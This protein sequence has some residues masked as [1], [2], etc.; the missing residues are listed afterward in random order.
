MNLKQM[1]AFKELMLTGSVSKAAMNLH[2]TQPTVSHLI[3]TFEDEL[4]MKLFVREGKRLTPVPETNYL[5]EECET[6]LRRIDVISENL[7]RMKAM[8]RGEMRVVSMPGPSA[9]L[10]PAL[11]SEHVAGK[12]DIKATVMSRSSEAVRHLVSS[13]QFD[14]GLADHDPENPFEGTLLKAEIFT[15]D[16]VCALPAGDPLTKKKSISLDDL[17]GKPMASLFTEHVIHK[18]TEQAFASMSADFNLRFETNFF[19]QLLTFVQRKLAYAIID[20][21]TVE[22]YRLYSGGAEHIVFR[23]LEQIIEFGVEKLLPGYRPA[24]I[25]AS[26]FEDRLTRELLRLG[27]KQ[28]RRVGLSDEV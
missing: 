15:F 18:R 5:L 25:L 4:E 7:K 13:Q 17:S 22:A 19:I 28:I 8:D 21:L 23:P 14:L 9:F 27:A 20:P 24:S 16:C 26:S 6:V 10:M 12:E 11:I 1:I 2:R 3:K